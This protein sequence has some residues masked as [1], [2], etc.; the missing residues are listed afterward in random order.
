MAIKVVAVSGG[1]TIK[2]GFL[3]NQAIG[4]VVNAVLFAMLVLNLAQEE[5]GIVVAILEFTAIGVDA[6]AHQMQAGVIF[7]AGFA[8]QRVP[9]GCHLAVGVIF[10]T[11]NTTTR[12]IHGLQAIC[13]IPFITGNRAARV[14]PY[15]LATPL[16]IAPAGH[17][18]VGCLLLNQLPKAVPAQFD[19]AAIGLHHGAELALRVIAVASLPAKGI[20]SCNHI[21]LLVAFK[22]PLTIPLHHLANPTIPI[23]IGGLTAIGSNLALQQARFVI[24]VTGFAP[25]RIAGQ[26][27]LTLVVID[28]LADRAVGILLTDQPGVAVMLVH[29]LTAISIADRHFTLVIIPGVADIKAGN[30]TPV[31]N[32]ARQRPFTLPFP[33][34]PCAARQSALQDHPIRAIAVT[35]ALT[36]PVFSHH[37]VPCIVIV[38]TLQG[39]F[40]LPVNTIKML[41]FDSSQICLLIDNAKSQTALVFYPAGAPLLIGA[42]SEPVAIK[43][44]H[45]RQTACLAMPGEMQEGR[46]RLGYYHLV[47]LIPQINGRL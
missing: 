32:R 47:R 24:V 20:P 11:A 2:A 37:Q 6:A 9:L 16:V 23:V 31:T 34:E 22:T 4:E 21:P 19:A 27:F 30:I 18:T 40:W 7:V 14:A 15:Y 44:R 10:E 12:Q 17:A 46:S 3:R 8:A 1:A 36:G 28:K 41:Q 26:H 25:Q 33:E 13:R 43:I 29:L 42:D 39:R 5:L 38:I 35:F 45:G